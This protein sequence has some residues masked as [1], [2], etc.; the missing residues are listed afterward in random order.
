MKKGEITKKLD[1]A[2]SLKKDDELRQFVK[3]HKEFM[4][5]MGRTHGNSRVQFLVESA[6][7]KMEN[8]PDPLP[9]KDSKAEQSQLDDI[10]DA[11][12]AGELRLAV[13]LFDQFFQDVYDTMN[14]TNKNMP[15]C[16]GLWLLRHYISLSGGNQF[17]RSDRL[18]HRVV[19][20]VE[21]QFTDGR[22]T[23]KKANLL[24]PEERK[25]SG[26]TFKQ[27]QRLNRVFDDFNNFTGLGM[28]KFLDI[29]E[30]SATDYQINNQMAV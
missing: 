24:T 9:D 11:L 17:T 16:T 5:A 19:N 3:N 15:R 22:S 23:T 4:K 26:F 25:E 6:Q 7:M 1:K 29:M 20:A 8:N 13:D 30:D 27:L 14:T 10:E 21:Q 18:A 12:R 28:E 2:I